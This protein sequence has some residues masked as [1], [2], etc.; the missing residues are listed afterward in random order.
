MA[1]C[2]SPQLAFKG[3][4][5]FS[6]KTLQ[7]G[8]LISQTCQAQQIYYSIVYLYYTSVHNIEL[9]SLL[10]TTLHYRMECYIRLY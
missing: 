1:S 4:Q 3:K 6:K 7:N 8:G 2:D 9:H 5:Q 10:Y